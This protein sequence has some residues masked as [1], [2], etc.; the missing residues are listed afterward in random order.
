MSVFLGDAEI[1][2]TDGTLF[3]PL[4]LSDALLASSSTVHSHIHAPAGSS[5]H[6][7]LNP[8][9]SPCSVLCFSFQDPGDAGLVCAILVHLCWYA[10]LQVSSLLALWVDGVSV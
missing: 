4:F 7:T 10:G 6:T 5:F 9:T 8:T 3:S 2:R 1:A